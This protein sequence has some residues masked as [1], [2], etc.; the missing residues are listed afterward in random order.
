MLHKLRRK[1]ITQAIIAMEAGAFQAFCDDFIRATY[2]ELSALRRHGLTADGK[3]RAGTPDSICE[4]PD[5]TIIAVEAST[6]SDYWKPP[7]EQNRYANWK[8]VADLIKCSKLSSCSKVI[9]CC[10][11]E[12][13]T[14]EP[15]AK[16][17]IYEYARQH[18]SFDVLI[19]SVD[20]MVTVITDDPEKYTQLLDNH[21]PGLTEFLYTSNEAKAALLTQQAYELSDLPFGFVKE[22]VAKTLE[23]QPDV[24]SNEAIDLAILQARFDRPSRYRISM[25]SVDGIDRSVGWNEF[26]G[27]PLGRTIQILGPPK[28]GKT[29]LLRELCLGLRLDDD[30]L[31]WYVCP[32]LDQASEY[33]VCELESDIVSDIL[34]SRYKE[35]AVQ[36][37]VEGR[38]RLEELA[39]QHKLIEQKSRLL[40]IDNAER[41]SDNSVRRLQEVCA[42][43]SV[44]TGSGSLAVILLS[45]RSLRKYAP[46]FEEYRMPAWTESEIRDL[47][48]FREFDVEDPI[49]AYSK[50]VTA[51]SGG[52]PLVAIA[53]ADKCKSINAIFEAQKDRGS[54]L[55]DDQLT[56][57]IEEYV[58]DQLVTDADDRHV[59]MCCA[60][61]V[62]PI[63]I[64]L[65]E[66]VARSVDP[67]VTASVRHI[68]RKDFDTVY[69]GEFPESI[70]VTDIFQKVAAHNITEEQRRNICGCAFTYLMKP[71]DGSL[72]V[73]RACDGIFYSI[74]AGQ[75]GPALA[76][77]NR[78]LVDAVFKHWGDPEVRFTLE[79]LWMIRTLAAPVDPEHRQMLL[80][81]L[82]LMTSLY[83]RM[84]ESARSDEVFVMYLRLLN[85]E[86]TARQLPD[87]VLLYL[88]LQSQMELVWRAILAS[89]YSRVAQI[90]DS[91]PVSLSEWLK[92]FY[93]GAVGVVSIITQQCSL[94]D[95]PRQF[96]L[97]F[98]NAITPEYWNFVPLL[99]TSFA[100]IG[101]RYEGSVDEL[102]ADLSQFGEAGPM[103]QAMCHVAASE[104]HAKLDQSEDAL[105]A[106]QNALD[107]LKEVGIESPSVTRRTL[108]LKAD[109]LYKMDNLG[110]AATL[111]ATAAPLFTD[112]HDDFDRA[113]CYFRMALIEQDPNSALL[114]FERSLEG[115]QANEHD[116]QKAVVLGEMGLCLLF[117]GKLTEALRRF[118]EILEEH[119]TAR[120]FGFGRSVIIAVSLMSNLAYN[121]PPK[122]ED[123]RSSGGIRH[124]G[125]RRGVFASSN[126]LRDAK[127]L[128]DRLTAYS[129][130][131]RC[132]K[133]VGA[134]DDMM[135]CKQVIFLSDV[136]IEVDT[137][138]LVEVAAYGESS[139]V[140]IAQWH[141][142]GLEVVL[143]SEQ[144]REMVYKFGQSLYIQWALADYKSITASS[145]Q[146]LLVMRDGARALGK[147]ENFTY[148]EKGATMVL[149]LVSLDGVEVNEVVRN[150][151]GFCSELLQPRR[152]DLP[153]WLRERLQL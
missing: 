46:G 152:A 128:Y 65:I 45:S 87:D 72:S 38:L 13:P 77:A 85:D 6:N 140:S 114:S 94:D 57:E 49:E 56:D 71:K 18:C 5:G 129:A 58:Y 67:K 78:M 23:S 10:S 69:E 60:A 133:K 145:L 19:I 120:T 132:Y 117:C 21:I 147:L 136:K 126:V 14:T 112:D 143:Q 135:R 53:I 47:L 127:P 82:F 105:A 97:R 89:D 83:R 8:P 54:A 131:A 91:F 50:A 108:V 100:H 33:S 37:Y 93:S 15:L 81:A 80:T 141:V 28:I 113:W 146:V 34:R 59:L 36:E 104:R 153:S 12:I 3:T 26:G 17:Q 125:L 16:S 106:A 30:S 90:I 95:F 110:A 137:H 130:L 79:R 43:L 144:V 61:L 48:I 107:L 41:L 101:I 55:Y 148:D 63:P 138:F 25:D 98:I 150:A 73:I 4:L 64:D 35:A 124:I 70:A 103:G 2:A 66:H 92:H 111:Y 39:N 75:L 84:G 11:Q 102:T 7:V 20:E 123:Y 96:V 62:S 134:F 68:I 116:Y 31:V 119:F 27:A 40:V 121:D 52:H 24:N 149:L 139:F 32:K 122:V 142:K 115:F 29:F 86:E 74:L 88:R 22:I 42:Y 109:I 9:L 118:E 44:Q 76:M 99:T 151:V 51:F 1:Q